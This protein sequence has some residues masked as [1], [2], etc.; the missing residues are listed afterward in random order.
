MIG[1]CPERNEM[2]ER[3]RE[4]VSRV[5]VNSLE[6]TTHNPEKHSEKVK[7]PV[8]STLEVIFLHSV[9]NKGTPDSTK[10]KNGSFQRMS[11]LCSNTKRSR[12]FMMNLVNL[13]IKRR[14]VHQSMYSVVK[15][16]FKNEEN[17]DLGPDVSPTIG[18]M[19]NSYTLNTLLFTY[20]SGKGASMFIPNIVAIGWKRKIRG[21]SKTK[22]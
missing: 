18:R 6:K 13:L 15:S 8:T 21:P 2:T 3:P 4:I 12:I 16:V 19:N 9:V 14:P 22:C 7:L 5:T 1:T 17:G 10:T 20:H 11:V